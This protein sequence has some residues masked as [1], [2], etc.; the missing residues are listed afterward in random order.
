MKD[1]EDIVREKLEEID[2]E[3]AKETTK[4]NENIKTDVVEKV[5]EWATQYLYY[6]DDSGLEKEDIRLC[7]EFVEKLKK[8]GMR[9]IAP[10]EGTESE[11]EPHPTFGLASGTIDWD[12]ELVESKLNEADE[13]GAPQDTTPPDEESTP[14]EEPVKDETETE[15][16]FTATD[17]DDFLQKTQSKV[18]VKKEGCMP[19]P[20]FGNRDTRNH[21]K[22][23]IYIENPKG[24]ISFL[25][26]DSIANTEAD[27]PMDKK[28]ALARFGMDV[29]SFENAPSYEEF[30]SE[31]GYNEAN[32]SVAQKA[33]NGCRKQMEK[34]KKVFTDE[35]LSELK[36]LASEY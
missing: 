19:S 22:Y 5:P 35:E 28:D 16:E 3:E 29:S 30:K 13:D 7:D 8:N 11:F 34:A 4:V 36:R 31:F 20:I 2:A 27:K 9:L 32:D 26:W 1:F 14:N 10:K 17:F 23:R 15:E 33:Y 18:T 21:N 6:G 25:F 12:V 24:R